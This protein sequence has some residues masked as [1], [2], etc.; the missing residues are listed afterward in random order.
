[1]LL[2]KTKIGKSK[3]HGIGLFADEFIKEGSQIWVLDTSFDSAFSID[4]FNVL[5]K[6]TQEYITHYSHF[7][8]ELNK[9]ILCGDNARFFNK[10]ENPNCGDGNHLTTVALRDIK[11]GEE[12]TEIYFNLK[13][14]E[15]QK[16]A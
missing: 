14:I 15:S 16:L 9:H 1:M 13:E 5:P 10:S 12:L 2:V 6:L 7:D 11:I 3:I 4:K 8:I